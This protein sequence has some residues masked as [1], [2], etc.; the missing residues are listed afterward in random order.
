MKK[1]FGAKNFAARTFRPVT[2]SGPVTLK[3]W[4]PAQAAM[5][6]TG[7]AAGGNFHS[8]AEIGQN[9]YTGATAGTA[10]G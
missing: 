1:T 8:G 7:S 6:V 9:Y 10:H 4:W 2:F 5:F 3:R